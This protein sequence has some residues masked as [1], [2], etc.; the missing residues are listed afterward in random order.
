MR[1][2]KRT[3]LALALAVTLLPAAAVAQTET[4]PVDGG[5]VLTPADPDTGQGQDA[6]KTDQAGNGGQKTQTQPTKGRPQRKPK[7]L[8][9][10]YGFFIIL[11][12][13]LVLMYVLMGRSRRKQEAK[14]KEML[15][16]LKKGDKVVS[17]GGIVGTVIETREDEIVVKVDEKSN[18]RMRFAR[19][20]IRA[21][22]EEAQAEKGKDTQEEK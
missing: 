2:H 10:Q 21:A 11:L 14:R 16:S 4:Q 13:G 15:Q 22:G 8:F 19:W 7:G 18:T 20:A 6:D 9:E 17:I 12:G 5:P 1:T 3:L